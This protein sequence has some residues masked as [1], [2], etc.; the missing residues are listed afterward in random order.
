MIRAPDVTKKWYTCI[1]C[2]NISSLKLECCG[3]IMEKEQDEEENLPFNYHI[4]K[5]F[6][7]TSTK[8]CF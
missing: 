8:I 3:Q 5:D 6:L 7:K 4:L 1:A 2:G